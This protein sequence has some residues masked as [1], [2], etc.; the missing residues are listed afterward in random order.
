MSEQYDD[1][2]VLT[3]LLEDEKSGRNDPHTIHALETA[4]RILK[5]AR[6]ISAMID[7]QPKTVG[8]GYD[9]NHRIVPIT[10]TASAKPEDAT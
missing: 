10:V 7:K 1:L 9:E 8:Y 3:E 2:R 5:G 4:V 6:A